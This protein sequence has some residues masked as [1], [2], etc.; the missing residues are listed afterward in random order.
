MQCL[1]DALKDRHYYTP[2]DQGSEIKVKRRLEQI[3]AIKDHYAQ[4]RRKS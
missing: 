2:G 4:I 3:K 1:P